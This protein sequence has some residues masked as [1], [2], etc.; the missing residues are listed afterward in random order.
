MEK[1]FKLL[2]DEKYS[3]HN[4][5]SDVISSA[6]AKHHERLTST[7]EVILSVETFA[8]CGWKLL[9]VSGMV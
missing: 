6:S 2:C 4:S 8:G 1:D 7:I 5:T 3:L 9:E